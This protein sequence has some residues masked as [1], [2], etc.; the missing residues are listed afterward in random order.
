MNTA[1]HAKP[2]ACV[3]LAHHVAGNRKKIKRIVIGQGAMH[4]DDSAVSV[5]FPV[6]QRTCHCLGKACY[7]VFNVLKNLFARWTYLLTPTRHV[8]IYAYVQC[9]DLG[10]FFACCLFEYTPTY[11][12]STQYYVAFENHIFINLNL[13]YNGKERVKN[14]KEKK[15]IVARN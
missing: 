1:A 5:H 13:I 11:P 10:I 4:V 2:L 6:G 9:R 12:S 7:E 15:A 14:R 8:C 3:C